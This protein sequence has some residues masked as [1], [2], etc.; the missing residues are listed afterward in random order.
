VA[1]PFIILFHREYFQTY[2]MLRLLA[3]SKTFLLFGGLA[4]QRGRL[5]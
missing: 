4:A 2:H 3:L 5:C 1:I